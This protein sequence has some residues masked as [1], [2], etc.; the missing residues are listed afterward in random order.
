MNRRMLGWRNGLLVVLLGA[1]AA[2]CDSPSGPV[3]GSQTNWLRSCAIDEQCGDLQCLCGAC[4][5]PCE[6]TLDCRDLEG[7]SCIRAEEVGAVALC[8]GSNPPSSG[9][10]LPRCEDEDCTDGAS[11]V[12]GVCEPTPDPTAHVTVDTSKRYQTLI[13]I[14]ATVSYLFDEIANHPDKEALHRAMFAKLGMDFLRLR[15]RYGYAGDDDLSSTQELVA[16]ATDSL[17]RQPVL[18]LTSF[19]PPGGLK[20]NGSQQCT[21]NLDTCT[22]AKLP[23]GEFDY[24]GFASHWRATLSAYAELGLRP[25]YIGLQ[26]NPNWVM[27]GPPATEAC[28]FLPT[29][30]T[31]TV[32][33]DDADIEVEFPGF[34][35]ALDAV[36]EALEGL[37][38]PPQIAAPE[39]TSVQEVANYARHM[40]ISKVGALAHHLYGI[41]TADMD[42]QALEELAKLGAEYD[43]PLLQ[44]EMMGDGFGTAVL[45]HYALAVEGASAYVQNDFASSANRLADNPAALINLEADTFTL[46]PPY[47]TIRHYAVHTDPDWVR[48]SAGATS[49]SILASAWLSPDEDALTVVVVNSGTTK[50]DVSVDPGRDG[51]TSSEVI[52]TVYDGVERFTALG[53]LGPDGIVQLPQRAIVTVAFEK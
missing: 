19:S 2:A 1:T 36:A 44:T 35:Q 4:T 21:G 28:R 17:G 34:E 38:S 47:H 49:S 40:D 53:A 30:G 25:D 15:N 27:G 39:V 16:A 18:M 48:V 8:S 45:M 29:Q 10:C 12:A 46:E 41:D 31:A 5:R 42:V 26:N 51:W 14:G 23:N 13:G 24:T 50:A 20:A 11:C 3:T 22:L 43:R 32:K 37:T 33:V 52:R 9:F 7:T 6:N